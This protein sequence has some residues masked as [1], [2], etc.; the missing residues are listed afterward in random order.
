MALNVAF[1]SFGVPLGFATLY[2][3]DIVVCT[4][5]ILLSPFFAV[6]AGGVGAFLGDLFFYPKAMVVTLIVR[7]VQVLV[8]SLFS[9]YV[10]KK[11]P[12]I[13]SLLGCV[14]GV[15]IMAFGYAYF[16]ALFYSSIEVA[17]TKLPL[18]MLQAIFGAAVALSVCYKAGIKK[19]FNEFID[20]EK[21]SGSSEK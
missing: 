2:L 4:A 15:L 20:K 12:F 7:S 8:I 14:I 6:V 17:A 11:K 21:P 19:M 9:K 5:G 13:S 1:S 16:A 10:L 3:T 18:E